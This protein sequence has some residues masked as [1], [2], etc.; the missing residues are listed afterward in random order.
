LLL[1]G[2]GTLI[3]DSNFAPQDSI[4]YSNHAA[5]EPIITSFLGK[6]IFFGLSPKL[7]SIYLVS[8]HQGRES[9]EGI[10]KE[11]QDIDLDP[12][13]VSFRSFLLVPYCR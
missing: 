10:G 12:P 3:N 7:F 4:N 5:L 1:G 6:K 2:H 11:K 9:L 13:A 8:L